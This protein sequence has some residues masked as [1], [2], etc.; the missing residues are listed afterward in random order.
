[1]TDATA[2][3]PVG[4]PAVVTTDSGSGAVTYVL[5]HGIGISSRYFERLIPVL[6]QHARVVAVDLP[7]FGRAPKPGRRM[8]VED[9]ADSVAEVID[10]LGLG[11][12]VVVGHSMGAQVATRV[13]RVRSDAVSA[14]ALIGPVM[15]V[16]DRNALRAA[17]LL[18]RDTLGESPRGNWL[19]LTDY[20]RCGLRWYLS[21]LPSMLSYR[22]ED[23]LPHLRHPV[24]VIR[25]ARDPI[26]RTAWVAALAARA[27]AGE[28]RTVAGSH[29][30]V[31]HSE[32]GAT[33][34]LLSGL[35]ARTADRTA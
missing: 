18:A 15:D 5:V 35:A 6:A 10:R 14:V 33:A 25:G 2:R 30:L 13:A 31:I 16:R 21:V 23:D 12:C 32:P 24:V 17:A 26:A 22:I 29:H 11:G 9:F 4:T 8:T 28:A 27:R 7:G 20:M 19:V 1:M 3:R 34:A